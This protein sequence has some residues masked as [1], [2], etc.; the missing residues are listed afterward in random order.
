V[1]T[2]DA[3][4][5]KLSKKK[6]QK[7]AQKDAKKRAH[8]AERHAQEEKRERERLRQEADKEREMAEEDKRKAEAAAEEERIAEEK[9]KEQEEYDAIKNLFV[10]E[11]GGAQADEI[12]SEVCRGWRRPCGTGWLCRTGW[13]C[14]LTRI[15]CCERLCGH[16]PAL[17]PFHPFIHCCL[18]PQSQGLLGEFVDFIKAKKVVPYE[19][20][21][22]TFNLKTQEAI[23]R[24]QA[25]ERMGR[26]TGVED[27][28][29]KFIFISTEVRATTS[30]APMY[31]FCVCLLLSQSKRTSSTHTGA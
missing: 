29:G 26:I 15:W 14:Y 3:Q 11:E 21:A 7:L 20:L 8:E 6:A 25:L 2:H 24:V 28:R 19:D 22:A 5:N 10:V 4:G 23:N 16:R 18:S 1:A 17:S 30:Y 9:R 31:A 13:L 12:E 27:D